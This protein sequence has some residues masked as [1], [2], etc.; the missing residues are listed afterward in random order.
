M[1]PSKGRG[2]NPEESMNTP[3][4]SG[5]KTKTGE[6]LMILRLGEE[7]IIGGI[8]EGHP[9]MH[10][11][12]SHIQRI[13]LLDAG[14]TTL[15]VHEL[16]DEFRASVAKAGE[17]ATATGVKC[18]V[19]SAFVMV[20]SGLLSLVFPPALVLTMPALQG[21][22][23]S[24]GVS[25]SGRLVSHFASKVKY[26]RFRCVAN[27]GLPPRL[28]ELESLE[29]IG[30]MTKAAFERFLDEIDNDDEGDKDAV[31]RIATAVASASQQ[32]RVA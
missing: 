3:I 17:A 9:L 29:F 26:V 21:I 18:M 24:A 16:G 32:Q 1:P 22:Y 30:R 6:P 28:L 10:L 11:P 12:A 7:V 23:I 2:G 13:E 8:S 31:I 27:A 25:F 19:S 5:Y 14:K 20:G 15:A 4:Y